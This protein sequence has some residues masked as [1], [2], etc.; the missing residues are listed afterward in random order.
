[1][2]SWA[3]CDSGAGGYWHRFP[4]PSQQEPRKFGWGAGLGW[5]THTPSDFQRAPLGALVNLW[6]SVCSL[7]RVLGLAK[8][9]TNMDAEPNCQPSP[10]KSSS[11]MPQISP[12]CFSFKCILTV[13]YGV[14]V[15]V[16]HPFSPLKWL[17]GG[18]VIIFHKL[19]FGAPS[20][21]RMHHICLLLLDD[22]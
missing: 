5:Q 17:P 20:N 6:C 14:G 22:C 3:T 12:S 15:Y 11:K 16:F 19:S 8:F 21:S 4:P 9:E 7:S 18:M 1:M 2:W 10:L 13:L